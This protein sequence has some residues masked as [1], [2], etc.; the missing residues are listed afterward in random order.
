MYFC[1]S[2]INKEAKYAQIVVPP[3]HFLVLY[4]F[5]REQK[6]IKKWDIFLM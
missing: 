2:N 5:H 6:N 1:K 3:I 4:I